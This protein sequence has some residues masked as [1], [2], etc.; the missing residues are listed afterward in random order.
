MAQCLTRAEYPGSPSRRTCGGQRRLGWPP[1]SRPPAAEGGGRRPAFTAAASPAILAPRGDGSVAGGPALERGAA[2]RMLQ[3]AAATRGRKACGSECSDA[4]CR[5]FLCSRC[6]V[7]VL[8]C[9]RCD[10]GQIYCFGGCAQEARR[11]R[12]REARRRYQATDRGRAMHADRNRRYRARRRCVTDHAF[13]DQVRAPFAHSRRCA[14]GSPSRMRAL[15]SLFPIGVRVRAPLGPA[16][17][18]CWSP[19]APTRPPTL[20]ITPLGSPGSR[21]ATRHLPS[22][23]L[24]RL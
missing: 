22:S 3:N 2:V 24:R 1:L 19:S 13:S 17:S 11:E 21:P 18:P 5:L 6:R 23:R 4:I 10:R 9:R 16:A 20:T 14:E 15:S 12:R 8:V 7:Q